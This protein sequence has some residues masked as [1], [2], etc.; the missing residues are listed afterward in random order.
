VMKRF[1]RVM[2]I[3]NNWSDNPKDDLID[4]NNRRFSALAWMLRAR[5]LVNVDCWSESRGRPLK[6]GA[7]CREIRSR[8]ADLTEDEE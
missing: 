8:L 1:R 4:E 5:F 2:T 3:E 7:I 6:P